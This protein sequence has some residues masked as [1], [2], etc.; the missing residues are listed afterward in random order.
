MNTSES[1]DL[2][3]DVL[4]DDERIVSND[5]REFLADLIRHSENNPLTANPAITQAIAKIAGEIVVKRAGHLMAETIL[6][7]LAE[8]SLPHISSMPPR[9]PAPQPPNP[10]PTPGGYRA[11]EQRT[12]TVSLPPRPP[13]PQ[14][15]NPGPTPGGY[16]VGKE[17]TSTL[18]LPPRPPAPQPPNPGPGPGITRA[19]GPKGI[20]DLAIRE[21]H[22]L[23][24]PRCLVLDEF[25]APAELNDLLSYTLGE[26]KHFNLSEVISPDVYNGSSV[27]FE[28]RRSHVLM[29]LDVHY[30]RFMDRLQSTLPR[31]LPK[32]GIE[33]FPVV[34]VEAQITASKDGDFF[35]W[36]NDNGQ[37]E[38]SGRK[39]TFVYFFHR[40]PKLFGGGELRIQSPVIDNSSMESG[41]Y[42]T[43]V[44]LQNQLVLFDS[45][46]MHE[47]APVRCSSGKFADSRFTVN[48]WIRR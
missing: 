41:N 48:G 3:S 7:K 1:L 4:L 24:P 21:K 18:S 12:R 26:E 10:G 16:R 40:E 30:E 42:Y 34:G 36:H 27:D 31:L 8:Q 15:P 19:I 47:I 23:V 39:I 5:E 32:L 13:A 44:P 33:P 22:D 35:R 6:R 29:D 14:P 17:R 20:L 43:I 9:P 11:V 37:D 2:L 25:L 28:H 45:S 46:L 38:V